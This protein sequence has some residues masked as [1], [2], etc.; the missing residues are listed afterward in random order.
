MPTAAA[1]ATSWVNLESVCSRASW[2][3]M[4][5]LSSRRPPVNRV[6]RWNGAAERTASMSCA[7]SRRR[8]CPGNPSI[9]HVSSGPG[10]TIRK[11]LHQGSRASLW[12]PLALSH[13]RKDRPHQR[14]CQ[15]NGCTVAPRIHRGKGPHSGAFTLRQAGLRDRFSGRDSIALACRQSGWRCVCLAAPGQPEHAAGAPRVSTQHA[16]ER[17]R[18]QPVSGLGVFRQGHCQYRRFAADRVPREFL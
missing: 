18:R 8:H 12:R 7:R 16:S 13:S 17:G 5:S 6:R 11:R 3:A 1:Q 9:P 10:G 14:R 15:R 2:S 4:K